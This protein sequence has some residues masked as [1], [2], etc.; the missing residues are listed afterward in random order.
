MSVSAAARSSFGGRRSPAPHPSVSRAKAA[1]AT[2]QGVIVLAIMCVPPW[3]APS[4][5][6]EPSARL[7]AQ[8]QKACLVRRL[9]RT[10]CGSPSAGRVRMGN[11]RYG[12]S[13]VKRQILGRAFRRN[14]H[15]HV[16]DELFGEILVAL[17]IVAYGLPNA[18][19]RAQDM[20]DL[21]GH[22]AHELRIGYKCTGH[23]FQERI[24]AQKKEMDRLDVKAPVAA[25]RG[26]GPKP[27]GQVVES[28]ARLTIEQGVG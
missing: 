26:D 2:T 23:V 27:R 12:L 10:R 4:A 1:S 22:R 18:E 11:P 28:A 19:L 15:A 9:S 5:A 21:V 16:R 20:R 6:A 17:S 3:Q 13:P 24:V 25:A 7:P 14:V 8:T